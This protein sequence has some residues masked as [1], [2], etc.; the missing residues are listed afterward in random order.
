MNEAIRSKA[1]GRILYGIGKYFFPTEK[2]AIHITRYPANALYALAYNP[3][4][5]KK[6]RFPI[7]I[8]ADPN[9]VK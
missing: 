5:G 3:M 1:I 8:M 4:I 7:I 6:I 2:A 9:N